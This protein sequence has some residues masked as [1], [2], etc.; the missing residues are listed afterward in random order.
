[1]AKNLIPIWDEEGFPIDY[2]TLDE[3]VEFFDGRISK[4]LNSN[5]YYKG[6]GI[7]YDHHYFLIPDQNYDIVEHTDIDYLGYKVVKNCFRNRFGI[8]KEKYQPQ[9]PDYIGTCSTR[10]LSMIENGEDFKF[11]SAQVIKAINW[12]TVNHQYYLKLNYKCDRRKYIHEGN[13]KS[14]EKLLSYMIENNWNFIW[15]KDSI[16][17]ISYNGLVTDSADLFRSSELKHK[18][19]TIYSVFYSLSKHRNKYE[20]FLSELKYNHESQM[21]FVTNSI[22]FLKERSIDISS[23]LVDKNLEKTYQNTV[24]NY[25]VRG[26][27]CGHCSYDGLGDKI[28]NNYIEKT[29]S[30]FEEV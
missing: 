27:N 14:L 11:S 28:M 30:L 29:K 10:E 20:E 13:P 16:T 3:K 12:D 23:L 21:S 9:F 19:G 26:K 8:F 5:L 24:L 6:I 18:I 15:D 1:M 4:G 22:L 7:N 17:D 2:L 25:L